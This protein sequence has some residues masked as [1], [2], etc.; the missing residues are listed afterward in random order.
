L[1]VLGLVM[2]LGFISAATIGIASPG[3]W[4]TFFVPTLVVV[5][6]VLIL[7]TVWFFL[8]WAWLRL[9]ARHYGALLKLRVEAEYNQ[10]R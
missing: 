1:K 10:P 9:K 7:F 4:N 6:F 8:R 5:P 3:I 2:L